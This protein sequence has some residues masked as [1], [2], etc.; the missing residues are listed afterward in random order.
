MSSQSVP[1]APLPPVNLVLTL[2]AAE[3]GLILGLTYPQMQTQVILPQETIPG[4]I[5]ALK[6]QY[7]KIPK[8]TLG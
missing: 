6:E 5:A 3:G 2:K 1:P 4:L 7:D 8:V